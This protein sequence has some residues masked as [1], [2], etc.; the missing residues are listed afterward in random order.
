MANIIELIAI[1]FSTAAAVFWFNSD[2][3]KQKE[4]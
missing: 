4:K 1:L 2:K 3:E